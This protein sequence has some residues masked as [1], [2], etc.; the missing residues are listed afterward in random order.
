MDSVD[1]S[2]T[3]ELRSP[4]VSSSIHRSETMSDTGNL[5]SDR[6]SSA[7]FSSEDVLYVKL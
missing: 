3:Q 2:S 7:S 4:T 1:S 5:S 6:E